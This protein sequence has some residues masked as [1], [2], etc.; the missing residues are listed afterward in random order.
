[1]LQPSMARCRGA[2]ESFLKI[3]M[4]QYIVS[5]LLGCQMTPLASARALSLSLSLFFLFPGRIFCFDGQNL[6]VC[7]NLC[8]SS[9]GQPI[10]T[11][12]S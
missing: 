10:I 4:F 8:F 1:M 3:N 6:L 9:V 2:N 5:F 12:V 7:S 11:Y